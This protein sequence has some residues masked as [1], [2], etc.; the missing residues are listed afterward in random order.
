MLA[1]KVILLILMLEEGFRSNVYLDHLGYETVGYGFRVYEG[2]DR[3]YTKPEA[4]R[5]LEE[6]VVDTV[7]AIHEDKRLTKAFSSTNVNGRV[8]M[9]LMAYQMGINGLAGFRRF[10][11]A[12]EDGNLPEAGIEMKDS[13]WYSRQT[14]SRAERAIRLLLA[15]G[16]DNSVLEEIYGL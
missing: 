11:S 1:L 12:A 4:Q 3:F 8:V 15:D 2:D 9:V 7:I 10:L 14:R 6:R 5:E 13:R 16:I